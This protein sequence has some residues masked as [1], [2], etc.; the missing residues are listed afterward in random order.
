[1]TPNNF[2]EN[3]FQP[4]FPFFLPENANFKFEKKLQKFYFQTHSHKMT[5][6]RKTELNPEKILLAENSEKSNFTFCIRTLKKV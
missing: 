5:P 4:F 3:A 1:M 2:S 6:P